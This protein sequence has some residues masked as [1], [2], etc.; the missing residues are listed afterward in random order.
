MSAPIVFISHFR[1]KDLAAYERMA[2]EAVRRLEA[3]KPQT[4]AFL[5]YLDREESRLT[6]VHLFADAEAWGHHLRGRRHAGASGTGHGKGGVGD[7]RPSQ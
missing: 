7:L 4:A 5:Q 6:I 2:P 3:E 1:V